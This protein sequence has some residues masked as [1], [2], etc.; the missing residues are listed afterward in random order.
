MLGPRALGH[1]KAIRFW[2][3][4]AASQGTESFLQQ[5]GQGGRVRRPRDLVDRNL[6]VRT[7]A[8]N[9]AG[10]MAATGAV[11]NVRAPSLLEHVNSPRSGL[12]DELHRKCARSSFSELSRWLRESAHSTEAH[13][14]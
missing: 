10:C 2:K 13:I 11:K 5:A 8:S 9:S 3:I 1:S 7:V 14:A 6:F 12:C 4:C